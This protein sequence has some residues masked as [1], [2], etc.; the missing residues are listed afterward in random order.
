MNF[1]WKSGLTT[2]LDYNRDRTLSFNIG[3][4]QLTEG[5]TRDVSVN[6]GYRKDKLNQSI[7]L[8]GKVI[9]LKNQLNAVCRISI[10]STKTHN[11][12]LDL[13]GPDPVT[14]GTTTINIAPSVDY[15]I[16]KRLNVRAFLEHSINRPSVASSFPTSFTNFGIQL[17]F[18]LTG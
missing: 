7:R 9:N 10:R 15:T 11:R 2:G 14:Q 3:N 13:E 12:T 1:I 5:K 16:S 18:S 6:I 4:K 8:F 17:R